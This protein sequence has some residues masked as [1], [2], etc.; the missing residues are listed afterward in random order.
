MKTGKSTKSFDGLQGHF[1]IVEYLGTPYSGWQQQPGKVTVQETL[2]KALQKIWKRPI[3]AQASG[4]TD[5]GVHA[6][7]QPVSFQA[8]RLHNAAVLVRALNANLPFTIRVRSARLVPPQFHARFDALG[9]TYRYEILNRP[10]GD[11]FLIDRCWHLPRPLD[12]AAMRRAARLLVGTHDFAS[13]TSNPGYERETT[14]R[15]VKRLTLTREGDMI[16][17]S[18]TAD[19]F[20]YRMVRNIV[21]GLVKVGQGKLTVAEFK[22]ARDAC[23]RSAAPASA[24]ACGLYLMK[25]YYPKM[26]RP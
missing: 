10:V 5:T 1:L 23:N 3:S 2:E 21:G 15:T 16:H 22:T 9:K 25:V 14:V 6:K 8:P 12:L 19:G 17:V 20:L 11:A 7:G 18:I 24:P 4:R 26:S 13:F